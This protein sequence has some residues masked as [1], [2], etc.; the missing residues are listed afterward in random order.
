VRFGEEIMKSTVSRR[1][2]L[3]LL[4][5]A[6]ATTALQPALAQSSAPAPALNGAGFYRF[7]LG[8]Y[9][10]TVLSDGQSPPGNAFP[11]WG[12]TPGR[13][14]DFESALR[15][16]YLDSTQFVNNFNPML[17]DTGR[18]KILID[19]GR[20]G[21]NGQLIANLARAGVQPQD[22]TTVFITH[23]HPDHVGGLAASGQPNFANAKLLMGETEMQFWLSQATP[24]ANLAALKDR[25]SLVKPGDSIASGISAVDT[26]GHTIGHLAV[27]V[28]SGNQT[29]WHLGDSG[30]HALLSLRFPDH[31]LGFDSDPQKAVATRARLW[32]AA[33]A[34]GIS[35]VGYHFPWPAVGKIRKSGSAYEYVPAFFL[36][37]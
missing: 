11:N 34:D 7:K 3:K 23:G 25:F 35:V 18:E 27:Q 9:T 10:L 17:I 22:I 36:F 31:Y 6:S 29:L 37:S 8:S 15:E 13:Q 24:P 12:A 19:T 21:Q 28:A 1:D 2:A 20:G 4:G 32:Q 14:A 5:L 26:S 16:N 30:G 33:A